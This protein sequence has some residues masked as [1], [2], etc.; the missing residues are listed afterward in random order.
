MGDVPRFKAEPTMKD[1]TTVIT[2][3]MDNQT[4][5]I[6]T[7]FQKLNKKRSSFSVT[8]KI[9]TNWGRLY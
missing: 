6:K 3:S 5:E 1:F 2:Q 9:E 8:N 7:G 4:N